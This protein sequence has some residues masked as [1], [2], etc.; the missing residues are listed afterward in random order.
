M[1][2]RDR[3]LARMMFPQ[4]EIDANQAERPRTRADCSAVERPCPWVGCRYHLYLDVSPR[5]GAIK[6]NFPDLEPDELQHTCV[7][8]IADQG[9]ATLDATGLL[10]NVTRERV[11]QL[12]IMALTKTE[13][14]HLPMLQ[15]MNGEEVDPLDR[16]PV[17][18]V[19]E[20]INVLELEQE[21]A[22][23]AENETTAEPDPEDEAPDEDDAAVLHS[24]PF[25]R[26]FGIPREDDIA[27]GG[28]LAPE[29]SK[30][31]PAKITKTQKI[32]ETVGEHPGWNANEIADYI[33]D[34]PGPTSATLSQLVA[35]GFVTA[36]G[37]P[38]KYFPTAKQYVARGTAGINRTAPA[39][40][41]KSKP[42]MTKSKTRPSRASAEKIVAT[43]TPIAG[44]E[45]ML[46]ECL[47]N[48][49]RE[50]DRIEA[51]LA[52]IRG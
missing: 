36:G 34:K 42:T 31:M 22:R 14:R 3:L 37:N 6:M 48:A 50:V 15:E 26:W 52:A 25:L 23:V 46:V 20:G 19:S 29:E 45:A 47:A 43:M 39:R 38:R 10:M 30:P 5:T 33:E 35:R 24:G 41:P 12:E 8:D 2:K 18:G 1:P 27:E 17:R 9:G 40:K 28:I 7:L 21:R 16:R 51:A 4:E 49:K 11:R 13:E 44:V 32:V